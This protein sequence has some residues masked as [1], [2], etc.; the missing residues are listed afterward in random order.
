MDG[1]LF[2]K[3]HEKSHGNQPG[4]EQT[5]ENSE[6]QRS[7]SLRRGRRRPLWRHGRIENADAGPLAWW[8]EGASARCL[9]FGLIFVFGEL[10]GHSSASISQD[11]QFRTRNRAGSGEWQVGSRSFESSENDLE[12]A[13]DRFDGYPSWNG[14][15]EGVVRGDE[16]P[17]ANA[18]YGAIIQAQTN[19]P[20]N[21]DLGGAAVRANQHL[22]GYGALELGFARFVRVLGIRAIG[23]PG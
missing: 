22:Q 7:R 12:K 1:S 13:E 10:V 15:V 17:A 23:A 5:R 19:R 16:T 20:D 2:R 11:P 18:L 4:E 14:A 21:A 6:E 3:E 8:A 9:G